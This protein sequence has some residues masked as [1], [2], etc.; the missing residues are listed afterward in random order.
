M[1][2]AARLLRREHTVLALVDVQE[3]LLPHIHDHE[4]VLANC[5]RLVRFA[6]ILGMPVIVCEQ[7]KLG[8]T[9][10]ALQ[11]VLSEYAPLSKTRFSCFGAE[12]FGFRLEDASCK[13]L[14]LAGIETHVCVLQ[15]AL[16]A[17]ERYN[18]HVVANA[19]GTRATYDRDMALR[20]LRQ[21]GAVTS[22]VEMTLFELMEQAGTE[23][24]RQALPLV[25]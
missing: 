5:V 11:A 14:L 24:F 12:G 2:S 10:G 15:T 3:R 6:S 21:A 20:R 16:E 13:N 7:E 19:T 25:K 9:V 17:M 8:P 18:V 22:S 1:T 4:S 23:E